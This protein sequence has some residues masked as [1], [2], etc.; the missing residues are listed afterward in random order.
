[1]YFIIAF[2][3][4][5]VNVTCNWSTSIFLIRTIIHFSRHC[6]WF[7]NCWRNN[8]FWTNDYYLNDEKKVCNAINLSNT[9]YSCLFFN[10]FYTF[11]YTK[12]LTFLLIYI[13]V[14]FNIFWW[15]ETLTL[16]NGRKF[17]LIPDS[18]KFWVR[19]HS[20]AGTTFL[21][22][23]FSSVLFIERIFQEKRVKQNQS[24]I[25]FFFIVNNTIRIHKQTKKVNITNNDDSKS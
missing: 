12:W 20:T 5:F 15:N 13:H 22:L 4:R 7:C 24:I 17:S 1:M 11:F 21:C 8:T 3:F 19:L 16:L 14:A 18:I 6:L 10:P 2:D 25:Y 23:C 9:W